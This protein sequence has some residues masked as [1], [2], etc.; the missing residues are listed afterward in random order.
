MING[1]WC[2]VT[3]MNDTL[4][5]ITEGQVTHLYL[6]IGEEKALLFDT[7]YGFEDLWPIL[8]S[9]V[10]DKPVI[11]VNSHGDFDHASGN[12]LFNEVY[13]SAHDYHQLKG[14]DN[15]DFAKAVL[16]KD[17]YPHP[18]NAKLQAELDE[19]GWLKHSHFDTC[20][21][22][23]EEGYIFRLGGRDLEVIAVPGHTCGS[24]V[25]LDKKEKRLFTGD[26]FLGGAVVIYD[27]PEYGRR[28]APIYSF[29][30][31]IRKLVSRMNEF[32][33]I[34]AA[35]GDPVV[36][37]DI[38][39][40]FAAAVKDLYYN[41]E[42]DP[43]HTTFTGHDLYMHLHNGVALMYTKDVL[44]DMLVHFEGHEWE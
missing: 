7:G 3:K 44:A 27:I 31:A 4:Y 1:R 36:S 30:Q 9:I 21:K 2:Q 34:H 33:V 37:A 41:H 12:Y 32:D 17:L 38:T 13:I 20:Y 11:A 35:H 28:C 40:K 6:I 14:L 23:I 18:E 16:Y 39:P 8:R 5:R 10:G 19:E 25:L 22:L 24:I 43:I 29:Y 42:N 26:A 15:H